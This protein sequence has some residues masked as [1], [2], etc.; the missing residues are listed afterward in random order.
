MKEGKVRKVSFIMLQ[1]FF[2]FLPK[3]HECYTCRFYEDIVVMQRT[4][5]TLH[6]CGWITLF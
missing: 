2:I 6:M 5:D 3:I 4:C 1:A